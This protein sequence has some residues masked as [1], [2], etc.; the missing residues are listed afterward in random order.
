MKN[1]T[2]PIIVIIALALLIGGYVLFRQEFE[3]DLIRTSVR[4]P[5]PIVEAGQTGFYVAKEKG[6]YAKEGLDVTFHH[7]TPTLGP[8]RAVATEIDDFGMI[9][10]LDTLLVAR[11]KGRPL[12]A[13]GILH[14]DAEFIA[15]YSLKDSGITTVADLANKKVGFF[16]GHISE[17][18][19]RSYLKQERICS[20][21]SRNGLLR[22]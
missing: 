19:I 12:K 5:I 11:G 13:V 10:G 4:F 20:T 21:R 7:S 3:N 18:F 16:Y 14:R 15:L 22:L 17:D 6:Y 1:L 2:I 9:G 8:I